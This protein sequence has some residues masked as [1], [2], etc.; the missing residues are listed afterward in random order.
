MGRRP[1]DVLQPVW[2]DRKWI[3]AGAESTAAAT[4]EVALAGKR[5]VEEG[6]SAGQVQIPAAGAKKVEVTLTRAQG[7]N[8]QDYSV[9]K[10]S[11]EDASDDAARN[12]GG[13][14]E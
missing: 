11:R 9:A 4:G 10:G 3:L 14:V 2:C 8:P 6:D 5:R 13:R 7:G 1:V 12:T